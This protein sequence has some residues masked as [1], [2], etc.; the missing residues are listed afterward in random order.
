MVYKD[1]KIVELNNRLTDQDQVLIDLQ[2]LVSE[3]NEVIRGR[4]MAVRLLRSNIAQQSTKL[5]DQESLIARLSAKVERAEIELNAFHE[6]L[7][8]DVGGKDRRSFASQ[9]MTVQENFAELLTKKETEI[10]ELRQQVAKNEENLSSAAA[11]NMNV[12]DLSTL[13]NLDETIASPLTNDNLLLMT[14]QQELEAEVEQL[15]ERLADKERMLASSSLGD[16]LQCVRDELRQLRSATTHSSSDNSIYN[17]GS[18]MSV[19]SPETAVPYL[20]ETCSL[21]KDVNLQATSIEIEKQIEQR[22]R[23]MWHK[24]ACVL[25]ITADELQGN[26]VFIEEDNVSVKS[27][28]PDEESQS[29]KA[30]DFSEHLL[31]LDGLM[32]EKDAELKRLQEPVMVSSDVLANDEDKSIRTTESVDSLSESAT[33][34]QQQLVESELLCEQSRKELTESGDESES[35]DGELENLQDKSSSSHEQ[36]AK[37]EER[38][39]ELFGLLEESRHAK[40]EQENLLEMSRQEVS[41]LRDLVATLQMSQS[42]LETSV[43]ELQLKLEEESLNSNQ[44]LEDLSREVVEVKKLNDE[45]SSLLVEKTARLDE[46]YQECLEL[47]ETVERYESREQELTTQLEALTEDKA[48]DLEKFNMSLNL[49]EAE[50][51]EK[52]QRLE[53]M[54]QA[55]S[56]KDAKVSESLREGESL[57]EI[58]SQLQTSLDSKNET[59]E[60]LRL[61]AAE[62]DQQ[63]ESM[64]HALSEKD[65]NIADSRRE[66]ESLSESVSHLKTSCKEMELLRSESMEKSSQIEGMF[67]ALAEKDASIATSLGEV[68]SL[69]ETVSHLRTSV[70][71]KDEEIDRLQD[72]LMSSHGESTTETVEVCSELT[73]SA[74]SLNESDDVLR[75]QLFESQELRTEL[76]EYGYQTE[77][78]ELKLGQLQ[79][80]IPS[81]REDSTS[82]ELSSAFEESRCLVVGEE[83]PV[84]DSVEEFSELKERHEETK[85]VLPETTTRFEE[86]TH[87]CE[88]LQET[89]EKFKNT[90]RQLIA[91]KDDLQKFNVNLDL[92]KSQ[93]AEKDRQLE[94]MIQA[95]SAEDTKIAGS[96]REIEC[97]KETISQ[98][99]VSV[100]S[101]NDEIEKQQCDMEEQEAKI[102]EKDS[103]LMSC[104]QKLEEHEVMQSEFV[105]QLSMQ[106]NIIKLLEDK[107]AKSESFSEALR[108]DLIEAR[109]HIESTEAELEKL[110][111]AVLQGHEELS[112]KEDDCKELK[113][114]LEESRDLGVERDSLLAEKTNKFEALSQECALLRDSATKYQKT[115]RQLIAQI[116]SKDNDL[117]RISHELE[118]AINKASAKDQQI[119]EM[120]QELSEKDTSLGHA[121][122]ELQSLSERMSS[123]RLSLQDK[124]H[125]IELLKSGVLERDQQLEGTSQELSKK[126]DNIAECRREIQSLT[127]SVSELHVSLLSK[128]EE[129]QRQKLVIEECETKTKEQ[130]SEIMSCYRKLEEHEVIKSE[131][132]NQL[133]EQQDVV[134]CLKDEL[135]ESA[136]RMDDTLN[137]L[138]SVKSDISGK[139]EKISELSSTVDRLNASVDGLRE[140]LTKSE[141]S[142]EELRNVLSEMKVQVEVKEAE[143]ERLHESVSASHNELAKKEEETTQSAA[144]L[145]ESCNIIQEQLAESNLA[146]EDLRNELMKVRAEIEAKEEELE[147]LRDEVSVSHDDLA[148][149][150]E[151]CKELSDLLQ[152]SKGLITEKENLIGKYVQE[153]EDLSRQSEETGSLLAKKTVQCEEQCRECNLLRDTVEKYKNTELELTSQLETLT[154]GRANDLQQ[155]NT[156]FQLLR[157]E[158]I[159]KDQQLENSLKCLEMLKAEMSDKDEKIMGLTESLARSNDQTDVLKERMAQSESECEE[160]RNELTRSKDIVE[161]GNAELEN[162]RDS[163]AAV[164]MELTQKDEECKELLQKLKNNGDQ[165]AELELLRTDLVKSQHQIDANEVELEKLREEISTARTELARK[166]EECQELMES[167]VNANESVR[168]L[169]QRLA[170]SE[171]SGKD[172]RTELV[173]D[174]VRFHDQDVEVNKQCQDVSESHDQTALLSGEGHDAQVPKEENVLEASDLEASDSLTCA[175]SS[176]GYVCSVDTL[177][178]PMYDVVECVRP[179]H[180]IVSQAT[181]GEGAIEG[182]MQ[183]WRQFCGLLTEMSADLQQTALLTQQSL[184]ADSFELLSDNCP[185]I[186]PSAVPPHECDLE[187]PADPATSLLPVSTLATMRESIQAI[188]WYIESHDHKTSNDPLQDAD[189]LSAQ[190]SGQCR[191][192]EERQREL[193][194]A[195]LEI[196]T[197]AVRFEKLKAKSVAKVKE[198]SQKLQAVMQQKDEETSELR[199]KLDEQELQVVGRTAEVEA[200]RRDLADFEERCLSAQNRVEE[201]EVLL[202]D[203]NV[204]FVALLEQMDGSHVCTSLESS[205]PPAGSLTPEEVERT[206]DISLSSMP[207]RNED[208]TAEM[209]IY[210]DVLR[211]TLLNTGRILASLLSS[212]E[213]NPSLSTLC[214]ND[215]SCCIEQYAKRCE[216]MVNGLRSAS[217]LKETELLSASEELE[218]KKILVNKYA[219]AA[220]KLK[221]QLEQS[222]KDSSNVGDELRQ[223][224][225]QI[226]ELTS[227]LSVLQEHCVQKDSVMQQLRQSLDTAEETDRRSC[228]EIADLRDENETLEAKHLLRLKEVEELTSEVDNVRQSEQQFR[229]ANEDLRQLLTEKEDRLN[230]LNIDADAERAKLISL[231]QTL[232]SQAAQLDAVFTA[233]QELKNLLHFNDSETGELMESH[234]ATMRQLGTELSC[235]KERLDKTLAENKQL[236][237]L[238]DDKDAE[239]S[240]FNDDVVS[241]RQQ[242]DDLQNQLLRKAEELKQSSYEMANLSAVHEAD[243]AALQES[244]REQLCALQKD[245]DEKCAVEMESLQK[246]CEMEATLHRVHEELDRERSLTE[247]L[248]GECYDL[249]AAIRD[250]DDQ[251]C[252][253]NEE[254]RSSDDKVKNGEMLIAELEQKLQELSSRLQ[255]LESDHVESET[256][257]EQLSE[258]QTAL[259]Q[260]DRELERLKDAHLDVTRSALDKAVQ[261][262]EVGAV[263]ANVTSANVFVQTH[264]LTNTADEVSVL[265]TQNSEISTEITTLRNHLADLEVENCTL[266]NMS[267]KTDNA[268]NGDES[269]SSVNTTGVAE[270][271][272]HDGDG[273]AAEN[274]ECRLSVLSPVNAS[275]I[276]ERI[277]GLELPGSDEL[278]SLKEKYSLLESQ[279]S[280]IKEELM[281]ERQNSSR[282]MSIEKLKEGLEAENEKNLVEIEA[283]T[284]TKQKM[285]AKLKELKASNDCL[286]SQVEDLKQQLATES[287]QVLDMSR[288]ESEITRLTGHLTVLEDEKRKW[289]IVDD[290]YKVTVTNLREELASR[291]RKHE[292][293]MK[294]T[295][296]D[297][298]VA[299][300]TLECRL[301][302]QLST[303]E[304]ELRSRVID[305]ESQLTELRSEKN[306]VVYSLEQLKNEFSEREEVSRRKLLDLQ[307]LH[308]A[309]VSDTESYQQLLEQRTV[310]NGKLEE[311][312]RTQTKTVSEL[313]DEIETLR[314]ELE[315][316]NSE[317]EE[318][319]TKYF[320]IEEQQ[321]SRLDSA[322]TELRNAEQIRQDLDAARKENA[323]LQEEMDGLNWKIQDLGQLEQELTELQAEMFEVQSE[324]GMLK[325]R[326]SFAE[327]EATD[328]S[329]TSEDCGRLVEQLS[330]EKQRLMADVEQLESQVKFLRAQLDEKVHVVEHSDAKVQTECV[331][332]SLENELER[333]REQNL[334]LEEQNECLKSFDGGGS[335]IQSEQEEI[336]RHGLLSEVDE[337]RLKVHDE[338][339]KS[340]EI[341]LE[342]MMQ[343]YLLLEGEN[344]RLKSVVEGLKSDKELVH[345]KV[346]ACRTGSPRPVSSQRHT[347]TA[348]QMS[349]YRY[350]QPVSNRHLCSSFYVHTD[351][352]TG[353]SARVS[354]GPVALYCKQC[355]V[356]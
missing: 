32:E 74:A 56:E 107:L 173:K 2:E 351:P 108:S 183:Q 186:P 134:K 288:L 195:R 38:C 291:E 96:L 72:Q 10:I 177:P 348:Q 226:I 110:R 149:K 326:L 99:E 160:L 333:L 318:L 78:D 67:Q 117:E 189:D 164:Q 338:R 1:H 191:T 28:E 278:M 154:E 353:L 140:Q 23:V 296:S 58:I 89:V 255:A 159:A 237:Q 250:K 238:I 196:E 44:Q 104:N 248:R 201:L 17:T 36:S 142:C 236:L 320:A 216:E 15:R 133:A 354:N 194:A 227:Q 200:V 263:L 55:L 151:H 213:N 182:V 57:T 50:A 122:R 229:G 94:G 317:K 265:V 24:Q 162:L 193:E 178:S 190:L 33:V 325:K 192:L 105:N 205:E 145:T 8:A 114:M 27:Q 6:Q 339:L 170:E 225:Q 49:D 290:D 212:D 116:E 76:T 93:A 175:E 256:Y 3:K 69:M 345:Q 207:T 119:D 144:G 228:A 303:A 136:S 64:A 184:T 219:A 349:L 121:V 118:V 342:D 53:D 155:F 275:C 141:T 268:F 283:L 294:K 100:I 221:Q 91:S 48:K 52:Q 249:T 172:L 334:L 30:E 143:V 51:L 270:T 147:K 70:Q 313:Q 257:R 218:A 21:K 168:L 262:T 47:T 279:Y 73:V 13:D 337:D 163:V 83:N 185:T 79:D 302:Q 280:R 5:R 43:S 329:Q 292:D 266:R 29:V 137:D 71:C 208:R 297:F 139:E 304:D 26:S 39:K 4:D 161:A 95:L 92:L 199:R 247:K 65:A 285:L 215:I 269:T 111:A 344:I 220:K 309:L 340:L 9:L 264:D 322:E 42:E 106:E 233:N 287:A 11:L 37:D 217:Q 267:M 272:Q 135:A 86:V 156:D 158:M 61:D 35:N 181:I 341:E 253:L 332:R 343:Q 244:H 113:R 60:V 103:K 130:D 45:V 18:E 314:L 169:R 206:D 298:E 231:K 336:K 153:V 356:I 323:A 146:C 80:E 261:D 84:E 331:E 307:T 204:Q 316:V 40:V 301:E 12:S 174:R 234:V 295:V 284:A 230:E 235:V 152:E 124:D 321:T 148:R 88:S 352:S 19:D 232:D 306:S 102:M 54:I 209:A 240:R 222:K 31:P 308:D 350:K 41:R 330:E 243:V 299:T 7:E 346:D 277:Q 125:E 180:K 115:E 347:A 66:I 81:A 85:S 242:I 289:L 224:Q 120:V 123:L 131:F 25:E 310:D 254:L 20:E 293:E 98:L 75:Q 210:G 59:I 157:D 335:G 311:L 129:I 276:S 258:M 97:L 126:D 246:N 214:E 245:F 271:F 68:E 319:K 176:E 355:Y 112:S 300:E 315:E 127:E 328:R 16:E 132:V 202:A 281:V 77:A 282:F 273:M 259:E 63:L 14:R 327:K 138:H 87:E 239:M 274:T 223:C 312:L 203:K 167:A 46:V 252:S 187:N 324:N 211:S 150:D 241:L 82:R 34:L 171:Q 179:R 101:R 109:T 260:K 198:L 128:D 166:E 197:G 188:R 251:L 286:L 305:Y 22:V 62:K 90:K 165:L